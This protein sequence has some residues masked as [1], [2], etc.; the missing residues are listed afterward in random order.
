[1][2]RTTKPV[3]EKQL[4]ANRANAALSTGPR[5]P[6][7]KTRSAQNSRKH[8]FT[9]TTFPV[10][11]LEEIDEVAHLR[12]DAIATY[13]PINSQELFAVER[14]ALA[15]Q[16]LLRVE[17]L[18]SG[19]FTLCLNEVISSDDRPFVGIS[20]RLVDDDNQI[21][22]AQNRNY[23]LAEG[24]H[25]LF[26]TSP[27]FNLLLRYQAQSERMY[28]R[29]AEEFERLKAL[30]HKLPNEPISAPQA[31]AGE[32]TCAPRQAN[33]P[34][35]EKPAPPPHPREHYGP[36]GELRFPYDRPPSQPPPESQDLPFD[37]PGDPISLLQNPGG[38]I[39]PP[40]P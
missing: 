19:I 32:T 1:M 14:I 4:A 3:S 38:A 13:Q 8:S 17:R 30:R 34:A 12:E 23:L 9:A 10:V 21:V 16:T 37:P 35:P 7:G 11:R 39:I 18:H 22:K 20:P 36:D 27:A 31:E 24:F 28:R 5:S 25:R 2:S 6:E 40:T 15:Q 33:P 26:K 29:A